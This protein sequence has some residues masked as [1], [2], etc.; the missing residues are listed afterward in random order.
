MKKSKLVARILKD[1]R[2]INEQNGNGEGY[3]FDRYKD[4]IAENITLEEILKDK[5]FL[6]TNLERVQ[7]SLREEYLDFIQDTDDGCLKPKAAA[8]VNYIGIELECFT[9][10]DRMELLEKILDHGL[11][12]I[13]QPVSDGSI[14]P[15]FGDDC[16]L[17]ILLPEKQ[18]ASGLRK[19]GKLLK[20]GQF[21]VNDSC[22]LHIHL[23]MRNR[24][25]EK[26]HERLL[27]FQDILF[28]MVDSERWNNEYC[29]YSK[30]SNLQNRYVAINKVDAY[31][32][33]KTIEVRLHHATLDMKRIEQWVKLLLTVIGTKAPPPSE[34]KAEVVKWGRKQKL[35]PYISKNFNDEWFEEKQMAVGGGDWD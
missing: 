4:Y 31:R 22:G 33:H 25:V 2:F 35:G 24:D 34:T 10:Y 17:R 32:Q 15:D 13:V 29:Q 11:G 6:K 30:V 9:H 26:C 3:I 14:E 8:K 16:E 7:R 21:G 5:K 27:K 28:G 20:K 1:K 18:L 12:K 19:L 23:D